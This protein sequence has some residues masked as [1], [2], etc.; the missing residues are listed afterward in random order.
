MGHAAGAGKRPRH[1]SD[2]GI[3]SGLWTSITPAFRFRRDMSARSI[4]SRSTP[5]AV[6]ELQTCSTT[7]MARTR[8]GCAAACSGT[9][10]TMSSSEP[11]LSYAAPAALVQQRDQRLQR[12]PDAERR[13]AG[14]GLIASGL[15]S[16][17]ARSSMAIS[18]ISRSIR[19]SAAWT[20]A[21]WPRRGEQPAIQ[22][23]AGRR[24]HQRYRQPCSIPNR[25]L[26]GF[27]Q[28]KELLHPCRQCR[29]GVQ[30]RLKVTPTVALIGGIRLEDHRACR[31][32][33]STSTANLRSAD[34]YPFTE[35]IHAGAGRI[36]TTWKAVPGLT[37]YSQYAT[38]AIHGRQHLQ[39]APDRRSS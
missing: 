7:G 21:S 37:F 33:R 29:A 36:G 22:C 30:D 31:A 28:T 10:A 11:G 5:H 39:P 4:R 32:P 1:R 3:V 24:F 25:G 19:T 16:I 15:S 9:S 35:N 20:T 17:T 8:C 12:Q 27:Q 14:R 6:H 34:G 38:A 23:G 13:R 26:Y 2:Q 18:A